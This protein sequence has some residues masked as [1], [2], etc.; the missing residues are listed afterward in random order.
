MADVMRSQGPEEDPTEDSSDEQPAADQGEATRSTARN[1]AKGSGKSKK[2]SFWWELFVLISTAL[3]LT[4]LLQLF[5]ARVFLIPS[6]SMEQTLH[7]C[8]GCANDRILVDKI[9]YRFSDPQPG[10]VI[11]FSGPRTWMQDEGG[12]SEPANPVVGFFQRVGSLLH[13][14]EPV[15]KDFVKR[16]IATGG[17]TVE[18]CD[19]QNRVLVDGQPLDEPYLYWAPGTPHKQEEFGPVTVPEDHLWVMGDNRNNSLD[20]RYQGG[21][22]RAGAVPL[23]DVVGKAQV[24]LLPPGRWQGIPEPNPQAVALGSAREPGSDAPAPGGLEYL[25]LVPAAWSARRGSLVGASSR[26]WERY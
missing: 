9:T 13:L 20:S 2:G 25:A 11:V 14:V 24:I 8:D 22:G 19:E 26:T 6:R 3:V 10:D 1:A 17:Q 18:C 4:V 5:V 21:G 23:D 12:Y 16:V 15:E 7:G